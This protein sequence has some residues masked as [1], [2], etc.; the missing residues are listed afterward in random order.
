MDTKSPGLNKFQL[1]AEGSCDVVRF[2]E[3]AGNVFRA[4]SMTPISNIPDVT[5]QFETSLTREEILEIL[6]GIPDTHVM[7]RSLTNKIEM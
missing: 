4:F 2:I 3:E 5:F 6:D 7:Q 1:R